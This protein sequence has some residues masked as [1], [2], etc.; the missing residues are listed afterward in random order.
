ML[1]TAWPQPFSDDGWLFEPKWDGVRGIVTWDGSA[2]RIHTRRGTEVSDRYPEMDRLGGLPPCV[3]DG[4]IVAFDDSGVPSFER[5][6]QRIHRLGGRGAAHPVAFLAFDLL[7]LE[8]EDL[9]AQPVEGRIERLGSLH[10]PSP[11]E[12]VPPTPG[13]GLGLWEIVQERDIE[14]M[15]AKRL[16]S[17]YRPGARSPDWRKIHNT[18][19]AKALVGGFTPGEGG[20]WGTFGALLLGL[21]RDGALRWVGAVGTGFSDEALVAIRAALDEMAIERSPFHRD[22]EMPAA[23]WIEPGL[24]AAVGYRNWTAA[25]RL[26]HPVFKGFTDDDPATIT[27]ETERPE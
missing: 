20:R 14:G 1:A 11:Y 10:L 23:T 7:H 21:P 18:H 5:L 27:W 4:E 17:P 16:G 2:A 3:L 22:L 13:D 26:R 24:V 9:T 19:T 8:G 15:V 25:G 12:W 6:Q